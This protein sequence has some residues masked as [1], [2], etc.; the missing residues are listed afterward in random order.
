MMRILLTLLLLGL[1][2]LEAT[3]QRNPSAQTP[4][5]AGFGR[6]ALTGSPLAPWHAP[7]RDARSAD[8]QAVALSTGAAGATVGQTIAGAGVGGLAGLAVGAGIG[9]LVDRAAA[10]Y[11]DVPGLGGALAGGAIGLTLGAPL[12]AH[13]A[14]R[15]AGNL[16]LGVGGSL[17]AGAAVL[18]VGFLVEAPVAA[19]VLAP[20]AQMGMMAA[21][22]ERAA[23]R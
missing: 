23:A 11:S 15:R 13:L 7:L 3:A 17:L 10:P 22:V 14:N 12:G 18:G 9:Y 6:T 1:F 4:P 20:L 19:A 5:A 16:A 2:P 8:G 21:Y